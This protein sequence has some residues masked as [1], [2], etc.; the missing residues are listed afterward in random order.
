MPRVPSP[1]AAHIGGLIT[2]ERLR[3]SMTQDQLAAASGIDSSNIRAYEGGRAMPNLHSLL[4]IADAF[5]VEVGTLLTGVTLEM[6][7]VS[8]SDGRR[9]G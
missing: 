8:S 6:F 5:G 3:V 9:R 7:P 4:R 1:A 2:A